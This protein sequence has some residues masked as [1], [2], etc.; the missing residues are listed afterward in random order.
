MLKE[1]RLNGFGAALMILV[2][3]FG[4]YLLSEL[5]LIPYNVSLRHKTQNL[6]V[7]IEHLNKDNAIQHAQIVSLLEKLELMA[8]NSQ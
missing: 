8:D 6:S 7:Q 1:K 5:V 4:L 2:C 3:S